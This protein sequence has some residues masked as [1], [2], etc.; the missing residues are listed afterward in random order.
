MDELIARTVAMDLDNEEEVHEYYGAGLENVLASAGIVPSPALQL[1]EYDPIDHTGV[2]VHVSGVSIKPIVVEDSLWGDPVEDKKPKKDDA[3]LCELHGKVC[4]RGICKVYEKQKEV[5]EYRK[6]LK[7]EQE[8]QSKRDGNGGPNNWRSGR[9]SR[10]TGRGTR[11]TPLQRIGGLQRD[12]GPRS[13]TNGE[14][15]RA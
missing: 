8:A 5:R 9:G 6:K 4:S 12:P 7:D 11:G 15:C 14:L 10:G 3:P 1:P 2:G 13:P